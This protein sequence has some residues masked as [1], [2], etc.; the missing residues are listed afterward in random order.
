MLVGLGWDDSLFGPHV[1]RRPLISPLPASVDVVAGAAMESTSLA[2]T[3]RTRT[4]STK[5]HWAKPACLSWPVL[6]P[7]SAC[8]PA[9]HT[10]PCDA[11]AGYSG[12]SY[13]TYFL[14]ESAVLREVRVQG[15]YYQ[16]RPLPPMRVLRACRWCAWR[17]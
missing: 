3:S 4:V 12:I 15:T 1:L 2:S 16:A 11:S 6:V 5:C 10:T 8:S 13:D 9:L 7:E 14:G 17:L